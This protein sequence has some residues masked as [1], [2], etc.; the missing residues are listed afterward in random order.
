MKRYI[1][2][3]VFA[4]LSFSLTAGERETIWPKGKMPHRQEHQIAAMTDEAGRPGF[5][6]D[7]HRTAYLE[8]YEAPAAD[9]RNGGCMIL[10]S[11]GS[12]ECCCDI[13]LIKQWNERFTE[14][15]FQCVN[16]VYRTPR[17]VGL[18]IYQTAWE[19]GQRAVRMVRSQ[20]GERGFDP[21]KIGVISM[22]AG[23]HLGLLLATSSQT[24]SYERVDNLDDIP[25]H[26]NWA[27]VNALHMERQMRRMELRHS[28][29]D[30]EQM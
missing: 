25:C 1:L 14:L 8:W 24:P 6:A 7:K 3:I 21:E 16:F 11:G 10:I 13:G 12:Y 22:S 2:L 28:D 19:D 18:P 9:K 4:L 27:I 17:P 26:L 20:A 23:S 15:G 5:N 30:M 29:R